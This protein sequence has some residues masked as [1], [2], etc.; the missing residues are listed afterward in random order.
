[1]LLGVALELLEPLLPEPLLPEPEP[2]EPELLEPPES[3]ELL[4]PLESD[5]DEPPPESPDVDAEVDPDEPL[6]AAAD[7]LSVR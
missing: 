6:A 4:D 2:L 1:M 5:L 3:P 7:R